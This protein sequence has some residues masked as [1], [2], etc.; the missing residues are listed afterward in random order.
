M[1]LVSRIC[2]MYHIIFYVLLYYIFYMFDRWRRKLWSFDCTLPSFFLWCGILRLVAVKSNCFLCLYGLKFSSSFFLKFLLQLGK[3][4]QQSY[5]EEHSF[6][7]NFWEAC[8]CVNGC[9]MFC[10]FFVLDEDGMSFG[11]FWQAYI[12][13]TRQP[14]SLHRG[15]TGS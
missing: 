11:Y 1:I 8:C 12:R 6:L 15:F 10:F 4:L 13:W 14:H 9:F 2:T 5:N 7:H 3:I